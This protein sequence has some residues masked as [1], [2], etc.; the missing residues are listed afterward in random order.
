MQ[1][2]GQH[3]VADHNVGGAVSIGG[4]EALTITFCTLLIVRSISR[5][6]NSCKGKVAT[7]IYCVGSSSK[8]ELILQLRRKRHGVLVIDN[9]KVR[10][11]AQ[12]SLFLFCLN[13]LSGELLG[14]EGDHRSL[15]HR[16]LE[17]DVGH[18]QRLTRLENDGRRVPICESLCLD[19]DLIS[20]R[21][22]EVFEL[23]R[24]RFICLET[25]LFAR[26]G[27]INCNR[28]P[29]NSGVVNVSHGTAD[30]SALRLGRIDPLAVRRDRNNT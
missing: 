15:Y 5:L 9:K 16:Y 4:P 23:E 22:I 1:K 21:R 8:S 25:P 2:R 3:R 17:L 19:R 29:G 18:L 20:D 11:N 26:S 6:P 10:N 24:S 12:N 30:A 14:S 28:C 7:D 13:L 27:S